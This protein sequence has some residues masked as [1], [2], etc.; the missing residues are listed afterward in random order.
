MPLFTQNSS[1]I[2]KINLVH[3]VKPYPVTMDSVR[4]LINFSLM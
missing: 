3:M 1:K 4:H 2:E